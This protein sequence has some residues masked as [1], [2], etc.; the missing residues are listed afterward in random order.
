MKTGNCHDYQCGSWETKRCPGKMFHV[1]LPSGRNGLK[2]ELYICFKIFSSFYNFLFVFK[3][4]E[5]QQSGPF[6]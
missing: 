4:L 6:C 3:G 5:S 2:E 1:H